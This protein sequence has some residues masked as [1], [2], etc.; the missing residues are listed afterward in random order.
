[1]GEFTDNLWM[2]SYESALYLPAHA[3]HVLAAPS[4]A[5]AVGAPD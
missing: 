4:L 2:T 3:R 5:A 1:V